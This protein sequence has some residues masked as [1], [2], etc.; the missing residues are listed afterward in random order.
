MYESI[1][2]ETSINFSAESASENTTMLPRAITYAP[3][4]SLMSHQFQTTLIRHAMNHHNLRIIP[5]MKALQPCAKAVN[6]PTFSSS[7][8]TSSKATYN[9]N[10]LHLN[11]YMPLTMKTVAAD[12]ISYANLSSR[13]HNNSGGAEAMPASYAA[14]SF[15]LRRTQDGLKRSPIIYMRVVSITLHFPRHGFKV[16]FSSRTVKLLP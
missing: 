8:T 1:L 5:A 2:R 7:F 15:Q 9:I 6:S 14:M 13:S 12:I 11:F 10:F 4:P 16:F 3:T